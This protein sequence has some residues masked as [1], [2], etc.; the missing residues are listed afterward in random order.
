MREPLVSV[1]ID[2]YNY[3]RFIEEAVESVLAQEFPR[4]E[5]EILVVDDGS[6]DDTAERVK[7]YSE[8]VQYLYKPNGG[9]ASAFNFGFA[10]ARG[11][12]VALLD[13]DD[14][15]LPGKL[16]RVVG[17]FQ[18]NA[19]LGMVYHKYLEVDDATKSSKEATFHDV[20]GSFTSPGDNIFWYEP[21][22]TSC[23]AYRRRFLERVLPVPDGLR[24]LADT[25]IGLMIPFAAAIQAIPECLTA[26]RLHGKNLY[27][28]EENRLS[29]ESRRER[30]AMAQIVIEGMQSW[31]A[32]PEFS[33]SAQ[34]RAYVSRVL[35]YREKE[36]FL[37]ETP[38]RL[39]YFRHLLLYNKC[40]GRHISGRLRAMNYAAALGTL[41]AG[42]KRR[43]QVRGWFERM[44]QRVSRSRGMAG[45]GSPSTS[46]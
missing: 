23:T 6:T 44:A 24:I 28:A 11:E 22:P 26:Y 3:G 29:A 15:W 16:G 9:Q 39:R 10:K 31:L 19:A 21:C 46:R 43:E 4:E 1:L 7:K 38:G 36:Q 2:A 40:F 45:G 14:Y 20:S 33:G 18:K 32:K 13:A 5:M 27:Y 42:Y 25:W 41:V 30:I 8:Q 34:A 12:I 17:E 35:L 37:L